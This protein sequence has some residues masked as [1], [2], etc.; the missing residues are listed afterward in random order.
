M[1]PRSLVCARACIYLKARHLRETDMILTVDS[2]GS[3]PMDPIVSKWPILKAAVYYRVFPKA[4]DTLLV[5]FYDK[6]G[7]WIRLGTVKA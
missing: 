5:R 6:K 1:A 7:K 4:D 3:L 2:N